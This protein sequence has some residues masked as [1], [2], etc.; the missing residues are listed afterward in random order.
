[1]LWGFGFIAFII[2]ESVARILMHYRKSD[3][4]FSAMLTACMILSVPAIIVWE[5]Y[6]RSVKG[7][8]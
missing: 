5:I 2:I 8:N 3:A 7:M 1:M 4:Y 6:L